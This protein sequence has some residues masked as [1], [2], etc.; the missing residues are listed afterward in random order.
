VKPPEEAVY[1]ATLAERREEC[2]AGVYQSSKGRKNIPYK[3][4]F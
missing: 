1:E 3:A 2:W 4:E